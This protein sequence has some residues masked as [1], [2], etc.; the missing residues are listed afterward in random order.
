MKAADNIVKYEST[1][2]EGLQKIYKEIN[3]KLQKVQN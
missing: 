1:Y 2:G 3:T